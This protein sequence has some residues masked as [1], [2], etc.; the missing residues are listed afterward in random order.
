MPLVLM[1]VCAGALRG[2]GEE[3]WKVRSVT[4]IPSGGAGKPGMLR[5]LLSRDGSE[6]SISLSAEVVAL[7]EVNES[8]VSG[9]RL[10]V[11]GEAGNADTVHIFDL[12]AKKEIDWFYCYR[13]RQLSDTLIASV[14]FYFRGLPGMYPTDVVLLYDLSRGPR[15]NRLAPVPGLRLPP[16]YSDRPIEVGT[17]IFPESN[18]RR[19]S[20]MNH[21]ESYAAAQYVVAK[22]MVFL[23]SKKLVFPVMVNNTGDPFILSNYL[24]VIDL[25]KGLSGAT[26]SRV[27]IPTHGFTKLAPEHPR[28]VSITSMEA[29]GPDSVR[30]DVPAEKYGVSSIVVDL[31]QH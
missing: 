5:A 17:P 16:A 12:D 8:Y 15:E 2:A 9:N 13:P 4:L 24:M 30:L 6:E 19:R 26:Y 21:V 14:E 3:P 18:F 20:Y 25:S 10:V 1:F 22:Q 31:T 29:A 7:R 11:L 27:N 28:F 23:D